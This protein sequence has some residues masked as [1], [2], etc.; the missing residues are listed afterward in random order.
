[1]ARSTPTGVFVRILTS[2]TGRIGE[3]PFKI[4]PK[5]EPF[6]LSRDMPQTGV[7]ALSAISEPLPWSRADAVPDLQGPRAHPL[8]LGGDYQKARIS[9]L[10]KSTFAPQPA[11]ELYTRSSYTL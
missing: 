9:R 10:E 7:A 11:P 8:F 4:Y 5:I 3:L 1:M 2:W 6:P